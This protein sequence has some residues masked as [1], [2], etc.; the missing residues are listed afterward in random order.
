MA[1]REFQFISGGS[2]K[3]WAIDLGT[4]SFDVTFGKIGTPGT[5]QTKSFDDAASA[6]K[7]H[8]KLVLE[9]TSKGYVEV[10]SK[11]AAPA[12]ET[13]KAT[14]GTKPKSTEVET[15]PLNEMYFSTTKNL[16]DMEAIKSFIG[17][18]VANYTSPKS[19]KKGNGH[20]YRFA[21]SYDDEESDDD[22]A[23]AARAYGQKPPPKSPTGK[24]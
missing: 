11:A 8:D 13:K 9:K 19:I 15:E 6:K 12:T 22:P 3:F 7:M 23:R 17:L 24:S 10:G 21:V 18:K 1:R 4:T 20:V 2:S 14:S 16:E 5:T